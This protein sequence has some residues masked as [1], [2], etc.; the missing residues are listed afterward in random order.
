M[1]G[2]LDGRL[3]KITSMMHLTWPYSGRSTL[4]Q[5]TP[6]HTRTHNCYEDMCVNPLLAKDCR[7]FLTA[8]HAGWTLGL[9]L[10]P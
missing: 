5:P 8:R 3:A 4:P 10:L 7:H 9:S 2:P 6:S 1:R